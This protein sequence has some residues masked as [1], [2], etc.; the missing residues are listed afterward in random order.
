MKIEI[1]QKAPDFTLHDSDKNKV[2]L[3]DLKGHNVLLLFFPQAFTGVCTKELCGVR[4]NIALYNNANAKVLGISVDSVF[5]LSKFKE[6]QQFN[7]PL[8][9]DFNKEVS[10]LYDSI[11]HDWILDMKGVS[12]RSAFVIDKE[13]IVRYAEVLESAGDVPDFAKIQDTLAQLN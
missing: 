1:G 3:S 5:T 10:N 11:Y 13:G 9:S 12:K 4:D 2:T 6:E 8:L 7:F